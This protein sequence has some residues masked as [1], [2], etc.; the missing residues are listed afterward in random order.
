M[1]LFL[2][3]FFVP[4]PAVRTVHDVKMAELEMNAQPANP[5]EEAPAPA[6][7][8]GP[9][10]PQT[11]KGSSPQQTARGGLAK[12][13]QSPQRAPSTKSQVSFSGDALSRPISMSTN[14]FLAYRQKSS[15][16]PLLPSNFFQSQ[17]DI[18]TWGV[19]DLA[20][21]SVQPYDKDAKSTYT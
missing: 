6:E 15:M 1:C 2:S 8:E 11:P 21:P 16:G 3:V 12:G 7:K 17:E 4:V 18:R 20:D 13:G 10:V 5:P 9:R 14:Q 19:E